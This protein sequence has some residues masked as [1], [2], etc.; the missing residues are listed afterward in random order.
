[1]ANTSGIYADRYESHFAST[2]RAFM[3][4]HPVTREKTTQKQLAE[5]LGVRP[6][7]VSLYAVGES[8]PDCEK[9]LKIAEY[10]G[11]TC[12]FLMTGKV[13]EYAP[14]RETLGF[15]DETIN[16]LKLVREGYF[17]DESPDMSAML[18]ALLSDKDFYLMLKRA[19][20]NIHASKYSLTREIS[21]DAPEFYKWKASQAMQDYFLHLMDTDFIK[22]FQRR[23]TYGEAH[24]DTT[25]E[26]GQEQHTD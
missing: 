20:E 16:C 7:T 17:E 26:G 6:Q 18:D 3:D 9:L 2:L 21:A 8:L 15:T 10:F 22:L 13:T 5:H 11:C 4:R 12:D 23:S 25:Q 24:G 14:I 19:A 1:M